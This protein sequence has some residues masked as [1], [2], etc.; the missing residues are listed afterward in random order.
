MTT[1]S[2]SKERADLAIKQLAMAQGKMEERAAANDRLG[3]LEAARDARDARR[4]IAFF[5]GPI[6]LAFPRKAERGE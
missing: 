4:V 6:N 2:T 1:F 3:T 5:G